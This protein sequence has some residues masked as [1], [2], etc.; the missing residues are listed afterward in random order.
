MA[1]TIRAARRDNSFK[2]ER[3]ACARIGIIGGVFAPLILRQIRLDVT[4]GMQGFMDGAFIG[5]D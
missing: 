3:Y 2:V 4:T 1:A 5:D